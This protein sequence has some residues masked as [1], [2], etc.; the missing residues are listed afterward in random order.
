MD[1]EFHLQD[2]TL[3][4][5][6]YLLEAILDA[7]RG[8]VSCMGMFAFASRA[9]VDSLIVDPEIKGYLRNS[10]MSLVVGIDAVTNRDALVRLQELEQANKRLS[11]Q[12]F[13][14]PTA[15]LFH[16][17]VARFKYPDGGQSMIVGSGNLTLG[18]LRQHFE[19]F[20]VMRVKAHECLDTSS[21]DRFLAEHRANLRRIDNEA[22]ERAARN[23]M[24]PP[25]RQPIIESETPASSGDIEL[26]TGGT[27]RFLIAQIPKAGARWRQ[28]HFNADVIDQFF[29]V[30]PD[31]TQRVCL[32]ECRQ[33]GSFAEPETRPCVY[34]QA[35]KNYKIEIASHRGQPYPN[36]GRPVAV[37][38]EL[39][40]RSFAYM[41][42]MPG[43]P[44]YD[45]MYGLTEQ[46]P[47]V[48]KGRPRA[49]ANSADVRSSWA[50][51]PLLM[52]IDRNVESGPSV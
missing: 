28:I 32:V 36:S 47:N 40:T 44:G 50:A 24:Q 45:E 18:G 34:S 10:T 20:S 11:I 51:C 43:D 38:H 9:G 33:D 27:N 48:G 4:D 6:V 1:C 19:A 7:S 3:S 39:Q 37:Y 46:L 2:P 12:V 35:N 13:W 42:L 21:L 22:L 41:L 23:I 49:I 31:S 5:P 16:P 25:R 8:A 29:R 17:K 26:P 52:T 14:N 30:R 15:A